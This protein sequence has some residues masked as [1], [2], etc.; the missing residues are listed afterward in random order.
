[1]KSRSGPNPERLERNGTRPS[2]DK[3]QVLERSPAPQPMSLPNES[4][5]LCFF[6]G[7]CPRHQFGTKGP[8]RASFVMYETTIV[9]DVPDLVTSSG[10]A[11]IKRAAGYQT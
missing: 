2:A 1:M 6:D 9:R 10:P 7:A 8:M 3:P 5:V 11:L 4:R